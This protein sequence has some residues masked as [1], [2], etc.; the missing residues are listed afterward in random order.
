[1][2]GSARQLGELIYQLGIEHATFQHE[3]AKKTGQAMAKAFD[4]GFVLGRQTGEQ[5]AANREAGP[6]GSQAN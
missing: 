6:R 4:D 5:D 2:K 1:M 3:I